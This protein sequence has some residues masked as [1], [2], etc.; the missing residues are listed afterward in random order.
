MGSFDTVAKQVVQLLVGVDQL[1]QHRGAL[2]IGRG[3]AQR[4]VCGS[5]ITVGKPLCH[6]YENYIIAAVFGLYFSLQARLQHVV[7][8]DGHL[9]LGLIIG[10]FGCSGI[11]ENIAGFVPFGSQLEVC[12]ILI[13][14]TEQLVAGIASLDIEVVIQTRH[15]PELI[16]VD[17]LGG[18]G[19]GAA[20]R[21]D[22]LLVLFY[23]LQE[24]LYIF[25]L[26]NFSRIQIIFIRKTLLNN[27]AQPVAVYLLI[28]NPVDFVIHCQ[29]IPHH[30][31]NILLQLRRIFVKEGIKGLDGA[32][33]DQFFRLQQVAG[34]ENVELLACRQNRIHLLHIVADRH[35]HQLDGGIQLCFGNFVHLSSYRFLI[36]LQLG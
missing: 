10:H 8:D 28:G 26:L 33:A 25:E 1:K 11:L 35:R 15:Y 32:L 9:S 31:G 6:R 19:E 2:G 4:L 23:L 14:I 34:P 24:G 12:Q 20:K 36:A 13:R 5:G 7:H 22:I 27:Q 29:P 30:L 16:A 18:T 17:T 21:N 3:T